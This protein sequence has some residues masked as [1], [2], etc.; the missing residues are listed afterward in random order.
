MPAAIFDCYLVLTP[1]FAVLL[2]LTL[3]TLKLSIARKNRPEINIL[4]QAK[5]QQIDN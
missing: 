4:A 1:L 3:L 2:M 5:E